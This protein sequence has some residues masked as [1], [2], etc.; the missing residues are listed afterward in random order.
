MGG[1]EMENKGRTILWNVEQAAAALAI[2]PWTVRAYI[3]QGRMRPIRIG[4]RVLFEPQEC[5]RFMKACKKAVEDL[6]A[7][8]G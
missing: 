7:L 3:R 5:Q 2:S 8:K 6:T 4:R 1:F